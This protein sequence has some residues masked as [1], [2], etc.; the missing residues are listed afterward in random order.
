MRLTIYE[1]PTEA[2]FRGT[3]TLQ[4][5]TK[6]NYYGIFNPEN[7]QKALAAIEAVRDKNEQSEWKCSHYI[8]VK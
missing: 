6:S 1:S 7:A 3:A 8:R 2:A 5:N 4:S